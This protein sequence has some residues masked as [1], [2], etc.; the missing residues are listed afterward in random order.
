MRRVDVCE[1]GLNELNAWLEGARLTQQRKKEEKMGPYPKSRLKG[2]AVKGGEGVYSK[3]LKV[4]VALATIAV[5]VPSGS[6]T[7]TSLTAP[8]GHVQPGAWRGPTSQSLSINFTVN[9]GGENDT[10]DPI[11]FGAQIQCEK[12][13]RTFTVGH[14]FFGFQ[15][16]INPNNHRFS[17]EFGPDQGSLISF[18]K[19]Q[20]QFTSATTANGTLEERWA[21]L[22]TKKKAE[23]CKSG[24]FT[25]T[26]TKRG[27]TAPETDKYDKYYVTIRSTDGS[28]RTEQVK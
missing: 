21:V 2:A 3:M 25:W 13:G 15:T 12:S 16:P 26:A 14:G 17:L 1:F 18:T 23:L 4:L 20:G 10:V 11:S 5:F 22:R 27:S 7:P 9:D 6:A 19:L 24:Q 28:V 8:T